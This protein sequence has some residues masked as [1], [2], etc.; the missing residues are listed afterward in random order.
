M[1]ARYGKQR[2]YLAKC[3]Y[4]VGQVGSPRGLP[5]VEWAMTQPSYRDM[6]EVREIRERLLAATS[7]KQRE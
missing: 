2:R 6:V 4:L 7:K 1:L 5:F 3:L